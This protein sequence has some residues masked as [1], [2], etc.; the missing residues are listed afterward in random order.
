MERGDHMHAFYGFAKRIRA[1]RAAATI[2]LG[3][4]KSF[5]TI[6]IQQCFYNADCGYRYVLRWLPRLTIRTVSAHTA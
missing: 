5:S 6:D 1:I 2:L 3:S 4:A